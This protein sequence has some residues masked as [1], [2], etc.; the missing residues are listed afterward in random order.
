MFHCA[1]LAHSSSPPRS[2]ENCRLVATLRHDDAIGPGR[3]FTCNF[4][5]LWCDWALTCTR[6]AKKDRHVM[7]WINGVPTR[8]SNKHVKSSVPDLNKKKRT[9]CQVQ[10]FRLSVH[11]ISQFTRKVGGDPTQKLNSK[12]K[13]NRN[14]K[15]VHYGSMMP[16]EGWHLMLGKGGGS[17][18][19]TITRWILKR[20]PDQ[21]DWQ[22]HFA[23]RLN[24]FHEIE[25]A[26]LCGTEY[27]TNY[28]KCCKTWLAKILQKNGSRICVAAAEQGARF[29]IMRQCSSRSLLTTL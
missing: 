14:K 25:G 5:P 23:E 6:S 10:W 7:V 8:H 2:R 12:P 16:T 26:R 19:P 21:E 11:F 29:A 28:E 3:A 9:M 13:P 24:Q 22:H 27:R 18:F 4:V 1:K 20:R 17:Q 15:R